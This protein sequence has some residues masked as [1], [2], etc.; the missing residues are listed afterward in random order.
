MAL[1]GVPTSPRV[2]S[3]LPFEVDAPALDLDA[4]LEDMVARVSARVDAETVLVG[5]DLGGVVAAMVA[6][7]TPVRRLVLTGTALG[8]YW[9]M[10]RITAWPGL[11]RYFYE[12]HAGRKFLAGAV[13]SAHREEVAAAFPLPS[14]ARMRALATRM[15]PPRGLAQS[16]RVPVELI[17]GRHDRWYPPA[18]AHALARATGAP[19]RWVDAGHLCNWEDPVAYGDALR[20]AAR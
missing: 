10:V 12:R 9:T 7:R 17:W 11:H 20:L 5:Q 19:I 4:T 6:A 8:P 16:L 15:T 3:R 2:W 1:H 13:G 18:V 14:G